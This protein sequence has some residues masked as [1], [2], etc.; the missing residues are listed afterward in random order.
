MRQIVLGLAAAFTLAALPGGALA[1][2]R[3]EGRWV[4]Q[5]GNV[6]VQ[7]APCG[8]ALCGVV[9]KVM[10]NRSMETGGMSAG[11]PPKVGLL[12][13]HDLRPSGDGQWTGKL[14]NRDNGRT[15]DC[16]V[17][18]H[19]Q[20]LNVRAYVLLPLFGKDLVWTRAG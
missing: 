5:T 16:V 9:V 8:G 19:G 11:P 17:T 18:P 3:P 7:I 15:Y 20:T 14:F 13:M 2:D 12:L 6:E 10:G 4:S 1:A